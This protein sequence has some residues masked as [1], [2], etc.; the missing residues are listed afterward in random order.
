MV[1]GFDITEINRLTFDLTAAAASA[2][3]KAGVAIRKTASDIEGTAKTL[4]PVDTGNLRNSIGISYGGDQIL[5]LQAEIGPT[6]D[7]G[8]FVEFGTSR[9]A[10]QAYM[11]PALDRHSHELDTALASLG[12]HIL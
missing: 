11:G 5:V 7:Y 2:A 10:P 4:A 3:P 6:A 8:A 9:M 1:D 12:G